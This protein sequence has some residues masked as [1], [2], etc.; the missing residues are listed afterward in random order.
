MDI[1]HADAGLKQHRMEQGCFCRAERFA[2]GFGGGFDFVIAEIEV[3]H[4]L[5]HLHGFAIKRHFEIGGG[6][7][8]RV[9]G[10]SVR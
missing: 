9:V 7:N 10:V 8:V 5:D 2:V 6:V 1:N 3:I 4:D